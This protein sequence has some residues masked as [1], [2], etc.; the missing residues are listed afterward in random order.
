MATVAQAEETPYSLAGSAWARALVAGPDGAEWFLA[1]D[2]DGKNVVLGKMT[3]AGA[4]TEIP[5]SLE[6]PR[7]DKAYR[8]AEAIVTGPDGNLWFGTR[9]G[10][11]RSTTAG[12]VTSF[13]LSAGSSA[14][15]AMA[16]GP[17]GAIWFTEG[18]ASRIGRITLSGEVSE[19]PLP[20]G[21]K[22]SGI[23]A[24]PDGNLW[25]TAWAVNRIGRIT[26]SGKVS[27]FAVPGP[28]AKL[29]SIAAGP[30]GNLWFGEGGAP[31]VGRITPD[32]A[33]TQYTVP[34]D[35]GTWS[36]LSGPGDLLWFASGT[37][38]GA[39]SPS[40]EISWPS[41]LSAGCDRQV[42]ALA[43]GPDRGIW[44]ASGPM[45]CLSLCGGATGIALSQTPGLITP[46]TLPPLEL[47]V[48]PRLVPLRDGR[49]SL[50]VACGLESGCR[51]TL[52]LGWYVVR[53]HKWQFQTLSRAPYEL[54]PGDSRRIVLRFPRAI[55]ADLRRF[56][57]TRLIALAGGEEGPSARRGLLLHRG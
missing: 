21:R 40:G 30:D 34:T 37:Q 28:W 15:T 48:G 45:Q 55:A 50:A 9:D 31:R 29:S 22:P 43:V 7:K 27:E 6:A 10:I 52:R 18:A 49:T 54:R 56:K 14:P 53:D 20:P 57:K 4:V 1:E 8:R 16:V 26:P 41:C 33:V 17:D 25:F 19:F 12:E 44:A 39:I 23:A 38:I 51:G 36:I 32:G 3:T 2:Y 46:Y 42:Y 5:L 11:G 24:G 47:A 35:G 13:A